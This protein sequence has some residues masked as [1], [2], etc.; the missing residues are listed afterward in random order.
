MDYILLFALGIISGMIV[1]YLSDV[2]PVNRRLT[3]PICLFCGKPIGF[4]NYFLWPR[5]CPHCHKRRDIFT[6]IVELL[7]VIIVFWL[8][9]T[10]PAK[11]GFWG[12][13]ILLVFF[14][15]IVVIDMRYKVILHP[16]SMFGAVLLLFI[17]VYLHGIISTL[18]GGAFG[19]AIMFTLY[20]LGEVFIKLMNRKRSDP[21][22]DVALG[23]G[24]VNL[25]GLLGLILGFPAIIVGLTLGALLGGAVSL[26]Y[27]FVRIF[28]GKYRSLEALPYGPFLI[29]GAVLLLFFPGFLQ[30]LLK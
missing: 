3:R 2:L 5:Q 11:L 21:V 13:L 1:N 15:V 16:V 18:A 23:F 20:K 7:F 14:G 6:W 22:N 27:I 29:S 9:D 17:G 10:A 4:L 24:D 12:G 8:A 26:V 30:S 19:F 25:A 28:Q